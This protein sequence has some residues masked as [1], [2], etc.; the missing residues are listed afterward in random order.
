[1]RSQNGITLVALLVAIALS[2]I[3]LTSVVTLFVNSTAGYAAEQ[4]RLEMSRNSDIAL[5]TIS[6]LLMQA[7]A[8]IPKDEPVIEFN[9]DSTRD[10]CLL[11]NEQGAHCMIRAQHL[12]TQSLP[13]D[14]ASRF[15]GLSVLRFRE[16]DSDPS[17]STLAIDTLFSEGDFMGGI[18]TVNDSIRL[19]QT[20]SYYTG[21]QLYHYA[22]TRIVADTV[23]RYLA[24][25][26]ETLEG[27][28]D[29]VVLA[30][31]VKGFGVY[32]Y[33]EDKFSASSW[34]TMVACSLAIGIHAGR[35]TKRHTDPESNVF[36]RSRSFVMRNKML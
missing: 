19:T 29:S 11:V 5:G 21:D 36:W 30:D 35:A 16:N 13:V 8:D 25:V 34:E 22:T 4:Q 12:N 27:E 20:R 26:S 18:D 23:A 31:N 3:L 6:N 28:K 33:T 7:G 2:G 17:F 24:V 1:M 10:L 9:Q 14:D 15:L 32:F